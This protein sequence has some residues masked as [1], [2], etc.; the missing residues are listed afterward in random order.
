M[1]LD[2]LR[3]GNRLYDEKFKLKHF[4]DALIRTDDLRFKFIYGDINA[5]D[6]DISD[7]SKEDRTALKETMIKF[8]AKRLKEK[9]KEFDNL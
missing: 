4:Y 3:K 7:L 2:E 5:N 8:A 1:T 6:F 9:E